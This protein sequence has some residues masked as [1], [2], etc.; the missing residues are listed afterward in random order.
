M[1]LTRQAVGAPVVSEI[2]GDYRYDHK[3]SVLEWQLPLVDESNKSGSLEFS[4]S[5]HPEDFFPIHVSFGSTKSF[6]DLKV[7][8]ILYY[9]A[10]DIPA[11][12]SKM[13]WQSGLHVF[14]C[15]F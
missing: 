15:H 12:M 11:S 5:G 13:H 14:I 1:P 9:T 8:T 7:S 4:I 3:R 2:E 6:C 10:M